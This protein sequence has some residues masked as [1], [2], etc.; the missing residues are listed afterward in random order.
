M[1]VLVPVSVFSQS[2]CAATLVWVVIW[3]LTVPSHYFNHCWFK[4]SINPK[5]TDLIFQCWETIFPMIK[6]RLLHKRLNF[7]MVIIYV[8]TSLYFETE[9]SKLLLN[10][11]IIGKRLALVVKMAP[12]TIIDNCLWAYPLVQHL[13]LLALTRWTKSMI[14][15]HSACLFNQGWAKIAGVL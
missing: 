8:E 9:C 13:L 5:E 15:T 7:I 14:L 2:S 3:Y 4:P 1:C 6:I 11:F 12:S 10:H